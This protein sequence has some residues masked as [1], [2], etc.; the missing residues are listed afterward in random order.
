MTASKLL[1]L[2]S[3]HPGLRRAVLADARI[4]AAFRFERHEFRSGADALFQ[5]I[6]L[7]W[8]SDA[9]AALVLYRIKARL[10]RSR[11]P[12]LPRVAHRLAIMLGQ[13]AIGDPVLIQPGVYVPHGQIVVDGWVEIGSGSILSPF[14]SIGLTSGNPQGPK[15]GANVMVGTG[16]RV[17]GELSVGDGAVIGANAVVLADVPAGA[18][19]V[20][21]P[22]KPI[23]SEG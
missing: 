6:R 10:Q 11:V 1:E 14:V 15:V 22:A 8:T 20:G 16:A 21:M 9:F 17:L 4:S 23:A 7:A 3:R 12:L 2:Q 19:V 5:V 13:V 18:T